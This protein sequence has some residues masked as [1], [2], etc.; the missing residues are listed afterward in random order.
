MLTIYIPPGQTSVWETQ[1]TVKGAPQRVTYAPRLHDNGRYVLDVPRG[2]FTGVILP[3]NQGKLWQDENWEALAWLG[4]SDPGVE[5]GDAFPGRDRPPA[6]A[7]VV[8]DAAPAKIKMRAPTGVTSYSHDGVEHAI[9]ED[10]MIEIDE[11]AAD[12]FRAFGFVFA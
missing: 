1:Q 11:R 3:S 2:F 6:I 8:A 10:G 12:V 9:G 7:P 4:K 5:F